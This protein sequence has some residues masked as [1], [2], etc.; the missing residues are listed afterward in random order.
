M[1][2]ENYNE[3]LSRYEAYQLAC[4]MRWKEPQNLDYRTAVSRT[5]DNLMTQLR[6]TLWDEAPLGQKP[7]ENLDEPL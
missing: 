1:K 4:D 6:V 3:L 7:W 2:Q 5:F